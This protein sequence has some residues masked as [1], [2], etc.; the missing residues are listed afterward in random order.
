MN[1]TGYWHRDPRIRY[2]KK[3]LTMMSVVLPFNSVPAVDNPR[4]KKM[5]LYLYLW[6]EKALAKFLSH[7]DAR[8]R[9]VRVGYICSIAFG[10]TCQREPGNRP[11]NPP[12]KAGRRPFTNAILDLLPKQTACGLRFLCFEKRGDETSQCAWLQLPL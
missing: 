8:G 12:L 9:S 5:M 6:E 4:K 7:Q 2:V 11:S 3:H 1:P 10:V